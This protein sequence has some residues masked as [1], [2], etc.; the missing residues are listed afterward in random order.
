MGRGKSSLEKHHISI[1]SNLK[2][3]VIHLGLSL[4][5]GALLDEFRNGLSPVWDGSGKQ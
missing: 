4:N 5:P 1:G 3:H 2:C